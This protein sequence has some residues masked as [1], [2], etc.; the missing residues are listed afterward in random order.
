MKSGRLRAYAVWHAFTAPAL[1]MSAAL[2]IPASVVAQEGPYPISPMKSRSGESLRPRILPPSASGGGIRGPVLA[3]GPLPP[4]Q[5]TRKGRQGMPRVGRSRA[6][7]RS[8]EGVWARNRNGEWYWTLGISADGSRGL[9]IHFRDFNI[10]AGQLWI[11]DG[12]AAAGQVFGPYTERGLFADGDFWTEVIF[13][14]TIYIEYRL[15]DG[16]TGDPPR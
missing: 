2:L 11:H 15:P 5:I 6:M 16:S 7:A 9:R 13:K 10:G 12:D 8:L 3:L 14:D 4:S 1:L